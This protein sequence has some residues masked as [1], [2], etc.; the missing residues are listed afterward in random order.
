MLQVRGSWEWG[1]HGDPPVQGPFNGRTRPCFAP[2]EAARGDCWM[3][4]RYGFG[5]C[6][7]M[8]ATRLSTYNLGM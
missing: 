3:I 7:L 6:E 4:P 5:S 8:K 1:R 2:T